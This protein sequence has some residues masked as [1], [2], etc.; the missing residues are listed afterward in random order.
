MIQLTVE[1]YS[2]DL[3]GN[4]SL[5]EYYSP[6]YELLILSP[7]E[8]VYVHLRN[9][10]CC[11]SNSWWWMELFVRQEFWMWRP[12]NLTLQVQPLNGFDMFMLISAVKISLV[13]YRR[14]PL[15]DA[16]LHT[17]FNLMSHFLST[18]PSEKT[19]NRVVNQS[20]TIARI[21]WVTVARME[22]NHNHI[23]MISKFVDMLEDQPP[24]LT[25]S[26]VHRAEACSPKVMAVVSGQHRPVH[27]L[28]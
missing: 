24:W 18:F 2:S 14:P 4:L 10:W 19:T 20:R 16:F 27:A 26:R 25:L 28:F 11:P 13:L 21:Y 22:A 23:S 15:C 1:T 12:S 9:I 7:G 8:F 3:R 5:V 6:F 17:S